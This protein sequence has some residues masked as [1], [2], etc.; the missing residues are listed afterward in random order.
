MSGMGDDRCSG[1]EA[2]SWN[3][4]ADTSRPCLL[5]RATEIEAGSASTAKASGMTVDA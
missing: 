4:N 2:E 5:R 3:G 1:K